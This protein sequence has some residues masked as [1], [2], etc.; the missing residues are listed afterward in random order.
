MKIDQIMVQLGEESREALERV[1]RNPEVEAT[2]VARALTR[3]GHPVSE[4][5][6]RRWRERNLDDAAR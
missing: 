2:G 6:V 3:H 4:A 5:A 1:L